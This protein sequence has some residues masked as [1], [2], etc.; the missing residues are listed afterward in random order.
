MNEQS[1]RSGG[2]AEA[3]L[4]SEE[5]YRLMVDSV[6]DYAIIMIDPEG[7]VASW[8]EGA[9]RLKG[10]QAREIIGQH[11]SRFY[12]PEAIAAGLPNQELRM[13]AEQGR[14]EDEGWRLRKDGSRF[15]ANVIMTALRDQNGV[16]RG[17]AKVTRD[18]TERNETAEALQKASA[19]TRSLIE[20]SLDPLVTISP[21]GKITDVNGAT[22]KV[23]GC[24]R[25]ELIG[26][27]FSGYFTSP[28]KARE[29]YEKVFRDGQVR[30]Y[31]L[32]IRRRDGRGISV[33]YN[34]SVY[35]DEKGEVIGVFAA[36]RDI[37]E[38]KR[39]EERIRQ[40]SREILE[41]STPVMQVWQ[42]VVAVPLIGTLDSQRTQQFMERLLDRIVETNSPVAL[43]DIMGVP[44]IDT[45]TAQHLI[46]TITAV[47]LL[48]AQVVLTGVR[49]AIAQTLVH[50]GVDLSGITTRSS[51]AAGL[52][53]ALDM[54]KLQVLPINESR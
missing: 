28:D 43:V 20:A 16:I 5:S 29:G 23:T 52:V 8:N 35:R 38:M 51:L 19:Y 34:A 13:A 48:G 27:D 6:V 45:Q 30:D 4:G 3:F 24:N 37:T 9:E 50:L 46:E 39:A 11:F 18:L 54:L 14:F 7:L 22:E 26:T 32:E 10:Y 42:G 12:P 21:E 2:H 33:L 49:P 25:E 17:F 1:D 41:L 53:V 47:R 31:P 15:W 40:Q 44:T 36:A